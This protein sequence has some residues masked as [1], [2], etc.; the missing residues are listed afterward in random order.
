MDLYT[1]TGLYL[2]CVPCPSSMTCLQVRRRLCTTCGTERFRGI[3]NLIF[4]QHCPL[5]RLHYHSQVRKQIE[6]VSI[7]Q[8]S[9]IQNRRAG[10]GQPHSDLL[11]YAVG[12]KAQLTK[13]PFIYKVT[14]TGSLLL[15]SEGSGKDL[16]VVPGD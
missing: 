12:L 3:M 4:N 11:G 6:H 10:L 5:S 14:R 13:L 16:W 7:S 15:L 9:H 2:L 8:K 1:H